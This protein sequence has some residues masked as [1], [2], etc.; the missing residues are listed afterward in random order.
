[1]ATESPSRDPREQARVARLLLR[2]CGRATLATTFDEAPYASLA[3][4]ATD[5]DGSPILLLSDLAR[6]TRNLK[7]DPR[8]SLLAVSPES[9]RDP[10]DSPRLTLLG[11]VEAT[12]DPRIRRRF[13][14]RHPQSTLY[15]DFQDFHFYRME[16]ERAHF[17][18]GF[19]HIVW[20][21]GRDIVVSDAA[22]A[23][24]SDE[25]ALIEDLNRDDR[26]NLDKCVNRL[27][28]HVGA[29]WQVSAI[30]PDGID[31]RCADETARLDFP[32]VALT[33]EAVRAAFAGLVA[34]ARQKSVN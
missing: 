33:S 21:E 30:D 25:E 13:L 32:S 6:A 28:G 23:L 27:A 14:A 1:M 11:R 20:I 19:G 29:G 4:L 34:A 7:A 24:A 2:R 9:G 3:L 17:I 15:A 12:N 18:G 31:A 5:L 10:L 22:K 26:A 16:I 8:V